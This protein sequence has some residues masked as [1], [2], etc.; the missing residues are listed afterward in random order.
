MRG[1][2]ADDHRGRLPQVL[3]SR[4]YQQREAGDRFVHDHDGLTLAIDLLSRCHGAGAPPGQ[5]VPV[6]REAGCPTPDGRAGRTH[7]GPASYNGKSVRAATVFLD[8]G[9]VDDEQ[10]HRT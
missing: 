9:D 8:Q 5:L 2:A 10:Y 7:R 4:G 1:G 6:S 3:R